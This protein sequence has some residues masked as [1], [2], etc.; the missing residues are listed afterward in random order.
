MSYITPVINKTKGTCR[1][2]HFNKKQTASQAKF[3]EFTRKISTEVIERYCPSYSPLDTVR[4]TWRA[5]LPYTQEIADLLVLKARVF[6]RMLDEDSSDSKNLGFLDAL[7]T[8]MADY[9]SAY[10][11]RAPGVPKRKVAKEILKRQLFTEFPYIIKLKA[12]QES[13]RNARRP[14]VRVAFNGKTGHQ[15]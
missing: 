8:R 14:V 11:M 4:N 2:E 15:R 6:V 9:L 3:S 5:N 7:T 12:T 10:T 1:M 13:A